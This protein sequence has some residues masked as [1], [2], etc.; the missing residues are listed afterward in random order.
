VRYNYDSGID[1]SISRLTSL[2]DYRIVEEGLGGLT[3]ECTRAV[4]EKYDYL[5][6]GTVVRRSHPETGIDLSYIKL[7]GESVGDA[8]DQYTGLDRFSRIVDQRWMTAA[9]GVSVDRYQYTYDRD[10]NRLTKSNALN[11]SLN[12]SYSYDGLNQLTGYSKTGTAKSWDYDA[13]GNWDGVTTNGST[14]TR[15]ANRQNE[16][17]S[18]SGAT[19]PTYDAVGNMRTDE[20][21]RQFVY[22]AW[23][24]LVTV[25]NASGTQLA[26]YDY[27]GLTRR[28]QENDKQLYYSS[29]WQVIEEDIP[30]NVEVRTMVWSPVYVDAMVMRSLTRKGTESNVYTTHDANLNVTALTNEGGTVFERYLRPLRLRHRPRRKLDRHLPRLRL[31]IPAPRRT[32]QRGERVVFV[33]V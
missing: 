29:S 30:S 5:G 22:D 26:R 16:I 8:G 24:R 31:A 18:I 6:A 19:T 3:L 28:V 4:L 10:G 23:N 15:T 21:G 17:T 11:S 27:D 7:S 12:E 32:I 20:T 14:Q 25:K 9:N 33:Q 13:L 1:D 2:S